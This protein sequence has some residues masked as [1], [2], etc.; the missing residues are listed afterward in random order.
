ME[1]EVK[2]YYSILNVKRKAS[3]EDIKK[4]FADLAKNN[5]ENIPALKEYIEAYK[6]LSNPEAR[7][8]YDKELKA[9]KKPKFSLKRERKA[10]KT[11]HP[12]RKIGKRILIGG[13]IVAVVTPCIIQLSSW[14]RVQNKKEEK[15]EKPK[16]SSSTIGG[17]ASREAASSML[18]EVSSS[19][20]E[21]EAEFTSS[22]S[23]AIVD[24]ETINNQ[25]ELATDMIY[26]NWT[27]AGATYDKSTIAEMIKCLNGI[28][29]TMSIE[30]ADEMLVNMLNIGIIP[31]VNNAFTGE[32]TNT[33][34]SIDFA[35]ILLPGDSA[36]RG[37]SKMNKLMNDTFTGSDI[38][39]SVK[40]GLEMEARILGEVETID[41][42]EAMVSSPGARILWARSAIGLNGVAGVLG[43]DYTFTVNGHV[44]TM[45]D[46]NNSNQLESMISRA[47]QDTMGIE[48][49]SL[50]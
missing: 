42:F 1:H 46:I 12:I 28:E 44:Y 8:E 49:I 6:V 36:C 15:D 47:K 45:S 33:T 11:N 41:G 9:K 23:S 37:V 22:T 10:G 14:F 2:D 32:Q 30:E 21:Q 18:E 19:T 13:A 48:P 43:N 29:S 17:F 16:S 27:A 38:T 50:N 26:E 35:N 24:D 39:E 31:A 34:V 40:E 20:S 4:S 3:S 5:T 25:I 7:E